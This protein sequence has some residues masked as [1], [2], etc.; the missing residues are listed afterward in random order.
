MTFQ[1]LSEHAR[2]NVGATYAQHAEAKRLNHNPRLNV[3]EHHPVFKYAAPA[4]KQ[5][6]GYLERVEQEA[7][8]RTRADE[9][10]CL[11]SSSPGIDVICGEVGIEK[12]N[13]C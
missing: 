7:K 3:Q 9:S 11:V 12:D 5:Q 2:Q 4:H 1:V 8:I 10:G 13:H 6:Q